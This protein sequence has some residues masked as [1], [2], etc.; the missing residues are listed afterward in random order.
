MTIKRDEELE[1]LSEQYPEVVRKLLDAGYCFMT[2]QY[3]EGFA[4][5]A[6][7]K[8]T[9]EQ[10]IFRKTIRDTETPERFPFF[11]IN[12]VICDASY[13]EAG[14]GVSVVFSAQLF[15]GRTH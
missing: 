11:L 2:C 4:T 7:G 9:H 15:S 8:L 6:R 3:P 12:A 10:H 1:R 14:W 5:S 13:L